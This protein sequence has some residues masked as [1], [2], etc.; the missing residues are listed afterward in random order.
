MVIATARAGRLSAALPR[1]LP[2]ADLLS[3]ERQ[4]FFCDRNLLEPSVVKAL[5]PALDKVY[6]EQM[7]TVLRQKVRV[8]LGEDALSQA[9]AKAGS[10]QSEQVKEFRRRLSSVPEGAIPFLQLFNAWRKSPAVLE[11]LSSPRL[12]GTAAQLLGAG[13]G[14]RVRLYQDSL[15]VKRVGDGQTHWHADLAMAP[16]DTNNLVTCWLPLQPVPAE[17]GGGSGLVFAA[18]SHRDVALPF[19]HGDPR[20]AGDISDRGYGE[21]SCG[22]MAL[23]DASWHHGWTLHCAPPNGLPKPRRALAASFFLDGATRLR[24]SSRTPDD[25][26]L[27]SAAEWLHG[28]PPGK[29][30]R[31][32]LL[33]VVWG[34]APPP[35]RRTPAPK[36]KS[37][38]PGRGSPR[39]RKPKPRGLPRT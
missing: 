22:A 8:V 35:G 6:D 15:F 5:I 3:F 18:G 10:S 29:A 16:L 27:E 1:T 25:E 7:H 13:P 38:S 37:G 11:L 24:E 30:A 32:P 26:D 21:G 34:D 31:H 39:A 4:G 9:E 20:E 19:W 23:G 28:V 33:P 12:A 36:K 17:G 2:A 14:H